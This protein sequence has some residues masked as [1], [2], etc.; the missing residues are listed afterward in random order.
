MLNLNKGNSDGA[1]KGIQDFM[2]NHKVLKNTLNT[3]VKFA[4]WNTWILSVVVVPT[5]VYM[6]T[7]SPVLSFIVGSFIVGTIIG[8]TNQK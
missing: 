3:G 6:A 7:S 5:Y 4:L 1:F 8:R 2:D